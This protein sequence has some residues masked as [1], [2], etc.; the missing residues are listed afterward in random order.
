MNHDSRFLELAKTLK[1]EKLPNHVAII[2]DGNGRWA[3]DRDMPRVFGHRKGAERVREVIEA[4]DHLGVKVLS[5]YVFSEENGDR[6]EHEVAAIMTLLGSYLLEE[7]ADLK[8][9]NVQLR[10]MGKLDR[11]PQKTQHIVRDTEAFLSGNTGLVLNLALSYGGRTELV[12]AARL[13]ARRVAKGELAPQDINN[14]LFTGCLDGW[15][16]PD[17]DLLIR[18]SGEQ[19]IS[20][21]MLWQL[22]YTELYF[23]ELPWPEF[24]MVEFA[25]AMQDYL[26]RQ[27]RFGLVVDDGSFA[28]PLQARDETC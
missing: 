15:D 20:S 2:M 23:T 12:E 11:L 18:T 5:L 7:R 10:T 16:L 4:A 9:R 17:P 13:L 1:R 6:P 26:R 19:R 22:A 28:R 8:A 3:A 24:G 27:R 21:F 14:E 25:L